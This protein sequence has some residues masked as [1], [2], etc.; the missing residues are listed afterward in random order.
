MVRGLKGGKYTI[1]EANVGPLDVNQHDRLPRLSTLTKGKIKEGTDLDDAMRVQIALPSGCF[2]T[3]PPEMTLAEGPWKF[4]TDHGTITHNLTDRSRFTGPTS[5]N[6]FLHIESERD[7][8]EIPIAGDTF[9]ATIIAMDR[10]AGRREKVLEHGFELTEFE[11]FYKCTTQGGP[12]PKYGRII[13]RQAP[14][15]NPDEPICPQG[16]V[17]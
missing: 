9:Q 3:Q 11:K 14:R 1:R 17:P 13:G 5:S 2:E 4:E 12:N 7:S 8:I 10:D 15:A 6:E 16:E